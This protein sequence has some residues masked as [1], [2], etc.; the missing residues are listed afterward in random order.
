MRLLISSCPSMKANKGRH[1]KQQELLNLNG[2]VVVQIAKNHACHRQTNGKHHN[3]FD[4][5]A[6]VEILGV[7]SRTAAAD[8]VTAACPEEADCARGCQVDAAEQWVG[9]FNQEL[10]PINLQ[11]AEV[12]IA[13]DAQKICLIGD[14]RWKPN[15]KLPTTWL[16]FRCAE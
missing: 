2:L 5:A 9:F 7:L 10:R 8:A 1:Q 11:S 16:R 15:Q 13:A 4:H 12:R 6:L 3:G 14:R